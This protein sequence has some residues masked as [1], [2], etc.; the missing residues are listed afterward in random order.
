MKLSKAIS[1]ECV[2][3][4]LTATT[5]LGVIEELIHVLDGAGKIG[6]PKLALKAVLEREKKMTT[7]MRDGIAIPHAKS[8][9][10][11]TLVAAVGVCPE[12]I[13]FEAMDKKPSTI[14]V[15]TL[16]PANRAGPHIQFI[17][18]VNRI[19]IHEEERARILAAESDESLHDLLVAERPEPA[20]E[21]DDEDD[22][23]DEDLDASENDS[24][25]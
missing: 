5:K 12:G 1:P 9:E 13:D 18:D 3:H 10:V 6:N 11:E 24:A 19:L 2:R 20:E 8:D 25:E 7:G 22:E 17:G 16:S 21:D 14:F 4:K 23:E 15:L